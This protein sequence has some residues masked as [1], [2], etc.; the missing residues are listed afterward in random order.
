MQ[1]I[2]LRSDTV[3]KPSPGMLAALSRAE[4]GDDVYGEDPT[5]N[6]LEGL[7]AER[8]GTE[9]ALL[10]TSGTQGNLLGL[11]TH[12]GRGDEY[13][14]GQKAHTYWLEGGGGAVLGGIQ[15]QPLEMDAVGKL[16]LNAVSQAIKPD[17][18]HCARTRLLCLE[19]THNG[20]PLPVAYLREASGLAAARGLGTHLDG[21]RIFNAAVRQQVPV[22]DVTSGF[23]TIAFCLS[24]GLGAPVGSLLCGSRDQI[25]E[26]RRWRKV[27]GGGLRQAG[28]LAAAG[29][30]A[31]EHNVHRLDE[32]HANA[33]RL[34]Q[35][36]AGIEE[37]RVEP[38]AERTNMVFLSMEAEQAEGLRD[39]LKQQGILIQGR[40][41]I[42]L[43]THLDISAADIETVL[44][45]FE[46]FFRKGAADVQSSSPRAKV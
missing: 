27:L 25:K 23:D 33:E 14:V 43:V 15:P 13:L 41:T 45:A 35:G 9:A 32:D 46:S 6:R 20:H 28:L 29:I 11:L 39:A 42:R 17:D 2:D 1:A 16:D 18:V 37:I 36:L 3:T 30:Y 19:N 5:V 26:A 22:R 31:L 10:T 12:C 21:A 24:K 40:G 4:V 8:L 34:A 38:A 44:A 7:A